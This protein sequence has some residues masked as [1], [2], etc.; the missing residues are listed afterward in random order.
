MSFSGRF[1]IS[2]LLKVVSNKKVIGMIEH[3]SYTYR[4]Q[5]EEEGPC[6]V[7]RKWKIEVKDKKKSRLIDG[8][9]IH[10]DLIYI[11][12]VLSYRITCWKDISWWYH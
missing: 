8:S 3:S 4:Q 1:L 2:L 10:T 5:T 9:H 7:M 12:L 11:L 6:P